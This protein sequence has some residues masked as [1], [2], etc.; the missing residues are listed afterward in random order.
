M[1]STDICIK[2]LTGHAWVAPKEPTEAMIE[3]FRASMDK[4]GPAGVNAW[5]AMRDAYL[6][7]RR[8]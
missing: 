7:E 2:L 3:A 8:K 1:I 6:K 5:I 4:P